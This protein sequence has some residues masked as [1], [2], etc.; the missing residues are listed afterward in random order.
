[1]DVD[2]SLLDDTFDES[3]ASDFSPAKPVSFLRRV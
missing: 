2:D 1:M 3:A